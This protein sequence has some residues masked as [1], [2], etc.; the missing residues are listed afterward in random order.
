MRKQTVLFLCTHNS[1][2]SQ[3]AEA[4][5]KKYAPEQFDVFSAGLTPSGIHPLTTTVMS[6]AGIDLNG[7]SA[8]GVGQFLGKAS[9]HFA[10]FVC[11]RAEQSCP[12]AWPGALARL[13]WPFEDPA[14]CQGSEQER[15]EKFREVRNQIDAKVKAWL[16]EFITREPKKS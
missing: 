16:S 12:T 9:V 11:D 2:R 14:A 7:H 6:E 5:L 8:K 1:A 15:L 4:F 3:M 13:F 10:V